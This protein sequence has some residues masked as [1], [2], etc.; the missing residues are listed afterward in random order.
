MIYLATPY[1]HSDPSVMEARF[2]AACRFAGAMMARGHLVFSPIAHTHP[3]AVKCGLPRGWEFWDRYDREMIA[4]CE[5]L[6]V[7]MMDGWRESK[8]VNAEIDIARSLGKPVEYYCAT[9]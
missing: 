4:A 2:D 9:P 8:G 5:K 3:I 1:T 6:V 7:V